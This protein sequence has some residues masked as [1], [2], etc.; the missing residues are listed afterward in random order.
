MLK[1]NWQGKLKDLSK[2]FQSESILPERDK[3]ICNVV[4]TDE[5]IQ[6]NRKYCHYTYVVV[7]SS[8]Y[9]S[10]N[11]NNGDFPVLSVLVYL[12]CLFRY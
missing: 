2:E 12:Q 8:T 4:A 7:I 10:H 5:M 1:M 9:S 6:F 11:I 3:N